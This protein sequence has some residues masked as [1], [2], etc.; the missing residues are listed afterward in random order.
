DPYWHGIFGGIYLPNL[1]HE[2]YKNLITAERELDE[3]EKKNSSSV[4]EADFNCDGTADVIV[5]SD[6]FIIAFDPSR[7]GAIS[8][9]SFKPKSFNLTNFINRIPEASH[10]K[11]KG[12]ATDTKREGAASIHD[13]V[14]TKEEGL[15]KHLLYDWYRH[16][17]F[18]EHFLSKD[19]TLDDF[20]TQQFLE[21]GDFFKS[22]IIPKVTSTDTEV[23]L[24]FEH[25]GNVTHS[26][27]N[28]ESHKILL[29][30][31]ISA[32]YGSSDLK[33]DYFLQN[34]S[35][36]PIDI[37]F[38]S[39]W[40]FG[41]LAGDA[42]DRYFESPGVALSDIDKQLRSK[43]EIGNATELSLTDEWGG[44]RIEIDTAEPCTFWRAPIESVASSEAGFERLYQGSVIFGVWS[45]TLDPQENRSLGMVLRVLERQ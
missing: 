2:V 33:I 17:C 32:Q 23:K 19:A 5:E 14:L 20:A 15:E 13:I 27:T 34:N 4:I 43:G 12:S 11:L 37:R 22:S 41:L 28:N 6:K 21:F 1:R 45:F 9:L 26:L 29:K 35:D 38:A 42:H 44:Y 16:G 39:E 10:E 24:E 40:T 25:E 36:T 18:I 31:N 8:E 3:V 7:G 30:K